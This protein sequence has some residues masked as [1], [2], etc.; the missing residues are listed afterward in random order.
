[1]VKEKGTVALQTSPQSMSALQAA[2]VMLNDP[3]GE[4]VMSWRRDPL[5]WAVTV[6]GSGAGIPVSL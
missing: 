5:V 4:V 3:L 1:M 6:A 2:T